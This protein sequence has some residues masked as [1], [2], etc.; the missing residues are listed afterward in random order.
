LIRFLFF[1]FQ[2]ARL[3]EGDLHRGG[4]GGGGRLPRVVMPLAISIS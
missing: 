2:V 1:F 3:Q 4:G